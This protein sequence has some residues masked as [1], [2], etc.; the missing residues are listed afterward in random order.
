M[1]IATALGTINVA[2]PSPYWMAWSPHAGLGQRMA[3]D[4]D[5]GPDPVYRLAAPQLIHVPERLNTTF[6]NGF[7]IGES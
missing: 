4:L 3:P 1:L 2:P 5:H 7:S 6:L